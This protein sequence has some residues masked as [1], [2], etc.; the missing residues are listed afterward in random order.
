MKEQIVKISS[1]A[2]I[3]LI[4]CTAAAMTIEDKMKVQVDYVPTQEVSEFEVSVPSSC[5]QKLPNERQGIFY[6]EESD[7]LWEKEF[8]VCSLE[9]FL[10]ETQGNFVTVETSQK[11]VIGYSSQELKEG[12]KVK[13]VDP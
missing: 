8:V 7:G 4:F 6:V 12:M 3:L 2:A 10:D 13:K 9:T 1:G 11:M 5:I